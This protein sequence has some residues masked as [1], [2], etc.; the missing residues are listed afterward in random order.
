[1]NYW[2]RFSTQEYWLYPWQKDL[3]NRSAIKIIEPPSVEPFLIDE[4]AEHLQLDAY[5]SPP[6][7]PQQ[8]TIEALISAS[9][10][11]VEFL[12]GLALAPQT[13][14]LVGRSFE[15]LA[16]YGCG[17]VDMGIPCKIAP[18][19]GIVS[20]TYKDADGV[21]T[22]ADATSYFLDDST[23]EPRI[24]LEPGQNWPTALD[25]MGNIRIRMSVGYGASGSSPNLNILPRSLLAAM[26][27]V[28]GFLY[29]QREQA[30]D[31]RLEDIPL[32][33]R[34]LVERYSIRVPIA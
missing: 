1:M 31:V 6:T 20:I 13:V 19:N 14:E 26:K 15:A 12:S 27:L 4:A 21:D 32:G 18:V 5:G 30:S 29:A 28:L 22:L 25:R 24:F 11:Y 33:A 23:S 9:R 16:G 7:Y 34:H 3:R 17:G 8:S 2:Y 10:E